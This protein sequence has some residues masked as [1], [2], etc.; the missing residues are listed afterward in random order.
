MYITQ[1]RPT[2]DRLLNEIEAAM[3]LS[4]SHRT[5][6][7]WRSRGDGPPFLRLGTAVRYR[8]S[9]LDAWLSERRRSAG[10]DGR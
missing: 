3:L 6:Q 9:E 4:L 1:I 8:R 10:S 2:D 7:C 5:L